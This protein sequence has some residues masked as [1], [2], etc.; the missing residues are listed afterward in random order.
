[1]EIFW[2]FAPDTTSGSAPGPRQGAASPLQLPAGAPSGPLPLD[3][4]RTKILE[5]LMIMNVLRIIVLLTKFEKNSVKCVKIFIT[6]AI[7]QL[8][9]LIKLLKISSVDVAGSAPE[10]FPYIARKNEISEKIWIFLK[11]SQ[12]F[13]LFLIILMQF[14]KNYPKMQRFSQW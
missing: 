11:F 9:F 12:L 7:L 2:G 5:P 14:L 1:M 6:F 13:L 8:S 10:P 3:S 4:P